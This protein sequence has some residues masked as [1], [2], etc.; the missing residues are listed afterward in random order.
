MN[1]LMIGTVGLFSPRAP[2]SGV[3]RLIQLRNLKRKHITAS[4]M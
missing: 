3:P 2:F 4:H 1:K